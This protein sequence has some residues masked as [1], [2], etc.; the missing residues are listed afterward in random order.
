MKK[1]FLIFGFG[2]TANYL[3]PRLSHEGYEVIAT[4]RDPSQCL[5]NN[6][7]Y[8]QLIDFNQKDRVI[9][10][11]RQTSHLLISTPPNKENDPVI[12]CYGCDLLKLKNLFQWVGYL[13]STGVYGDH[14]GAWVNENSLT[15]P[16]SIR[17][18]VRVQAEQAWLNIARD[19]FPIHL[20]RLAG[21]YGPYR[22]AL[23][24]I[25]NGKSFSV[26]KEGQYFSRIHVIDIINIIMA[27]INKPKPNS[28]YNMADDLPT[29]SHEV[30]QFAAK[31]L[32]QQALPLIPFE[33]AQL[34]PMAQD[35]YC[36][37]RKV[38]NKKIKQ[39][40]GVELNYP[41]Y[42]QGLTQLFNNKEY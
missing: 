15:Q 3:A 41:S 19:N 20:F 7:T 35:F 30:D 39:E 33:K 42:Q 17:A 12:D 24:D 8:C 21:I 1:I 34:S 4:S 27:S 22:N 36:A 29:P 13:S 26:Y 10:L 14:H 6:N 5:Y 37:N 11:L 32:H 28:I 18:K 31:L 16:V 25:N 23:S 40:L 38:S 2:Y 9:D